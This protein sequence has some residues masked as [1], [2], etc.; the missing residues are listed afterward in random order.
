M[1]AANVDSNAVITDPG[2]KFVDPQSQAPNPATQQ[3]RC[4]VF[5]T[6]GD[7]IS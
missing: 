4:R 7:G 3:G 5:T 6:D 2:Y 1:D